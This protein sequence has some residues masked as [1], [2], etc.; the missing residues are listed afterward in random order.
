[1]SQSEI[2]LSQELDGSL[3]AF[4]TSKRP[5]PEPV[6][7]SQEIRDRGSTFVANIYQA[8][9]PQIAKSRFLHMKHTVHRTRKASHEIYAWRC[10]VLKSGRT[11]LEGP[12]D[13]ELLQGSKDDGESWAGGKVLK[14]MQNLG[15]IDAVVIVTRWYGGTMLGPARFSHIETCAMEVCQAFK[16]SEELRDSISILQT[17]DDMLA[18]HRAELTALTPKSE[19]EQGPSSTPTDQEAS[20]ASSSQR[21]TKKQSY[22][23]MDM[24]KAKRLIQARENSIKSVKAMIGKKKNSTPS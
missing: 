5:P 2:F 19:E 21:E 11:G 9:T 4:V 22:K 12:D 13:F 14:V 6:A 1:M 24:T 16:Q 18:Q 3:D 8:N 23:D 20:S 10:M 17:L 15:I 7:T